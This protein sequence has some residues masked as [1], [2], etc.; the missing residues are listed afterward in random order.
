MEDVMENRGIKEMQ[1]RGKQLERDQMC[2][3][4][5]C[6]DGHVVVEERAD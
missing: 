3:S 1:G 5:R 4:R 6:A 2:I